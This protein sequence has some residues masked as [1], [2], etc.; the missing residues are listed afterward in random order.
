MTMSAD[1]FTV[2][3]INIRAGDQTVSESDLV[4][5]IGRS[6]TLNVNRLLHG[7]K[8]ST[9]LHRKRFMLLDDDAKRYFLGAKIDVEYTKTL[10]SDRLLDPLL[11]I[12]MPSGHKKLIDGHHRGYRRLMLGTPNA[13]V[14]EISFR[15]IP[16]DCVVRKIIV[17]QGCEPYELDWQEMC[18]P[19]SA[20]SRR[21]G[22]P[23]YSIRT[24]GPE[25]LP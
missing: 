4:P 10:S 3:N 22:I 9:L 18:D 25:T 23:V 13:V 2:M 15:D 6:G 5:Y 14:A 11:G 12:E 7:I 1:D 16:P 17:R 8:S 21:L 24:T 19:A 20:I